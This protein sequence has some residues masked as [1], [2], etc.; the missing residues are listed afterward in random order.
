MTYVSP[1]GDPYTDHDG[2]DPLCISRAH[3]AEDVVE[4][5]AEFYVAARAAINDGA[6][7]PAFF[8]SRHL[9]EL[10]LKALHPDYRNSKSLRTSHDLGKFLDELDSRGD[11]LLDANSERK[12]LVAFIRDL[13]RHDRRG[14]EGRYHLTKEGTP[15][16]STVCCADRKILTQE[17]ERLYQY[18][19]R[20][21]RSHAAGNV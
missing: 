18:V 7:Q 6:A 8:L 1:F 17:V 16:L 4:T 19:A 12:H 15:S 14:D 9:A 21:L 20:R 5:L 10:S 13:D 3:V 11:E 2:D